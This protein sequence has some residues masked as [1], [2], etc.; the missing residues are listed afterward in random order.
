M[1]ALATPSSPGTSAPS[2]WQRLCLLGILLASAPLDAADLDA[3][4][5][6]FIDGAYEEVIATSMTGRREE[7]GNAEWPIL[8]GEALGQ[9]GRYTE[10]ADALQEACRDFPLELRLRFAAWQATREAGRG[11]EAGEHLNE[12]ERLATVRLWA[13]RTPADRITLGRLALIFGADPKKVLEQFY[14]PIRKAQPELRESYLATGELALEK[15]DFALAAKNFGVAV[16]KFPDDPDAWFGLA[17]AYDPSDSEAMLH[18]LGKVLDL[19][20]N[21]VGAWLL[22]A[23][24]RIDTEEYAEADIALAAA[25]KINANHPEAHACRAVLAHLRSDS[26]LEASERVAALK[27]W[28]DNPAVPHLIGRKLS[29]KYRFAEGAA[30]QRE[31]LKFDGKFLPAKA[32]LANDLLRLGRDDEGWKL[33]GEVQQADPYD[34]VAYNL[35]TLRDVIAKFRTL[36]SE[37]FTVR[38]DPREAD[39]YG[40]DA[41]ALLERAHAALTKKYGLPLRDRTI[42]EIFPD[43]KDFA[44]RTFGL[45]GGAGYLGVCFGRVITAN[46]PASRAG[47]PSSWEAILWHE[48]CHVVTLTMTK[49]KMPRWLSEGISVFEERQARGSW[50]EQMKPRYRA[51]ILGED[52]TPVSQLSS[53]FLKPKTPAH[54][55]FAYY[56]SSLVVEWLAGRWGMEK[57]KQLLA[58]LGRGAEINAALATHFAPI[59]Q[60]DRDFAKHVQELA[61]NTGPKLDWTPPKPADLANAKS[62]ADFLMKNPDNFAALT[63]L[64]QELLDSRQ[65]EAAKKPLLR[66][67]EDYPDEHAADGAYAMLARVHRELGE[68][69]AELAVLTRLGELS[70]DA[71]D[72][73]ERLMQIHAQRREWVKVLEYSARYR[74][75]DPLRPEPWRYEAEASEAAGRNAN[76]IAACR[77]LIELGPSDP[78]GIHYRLAKLL[79]A[80]GDP[81]AKREVLLALEEAPRFR[82]AHE[83]LLEIAGET[84]AP[85]GV[86]RDKRR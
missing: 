70:A 1:R 23:N 38:M 81:G 65:W 22:L 3:A 28:R 30:L 35:T 25:L 37:H 43:Q 80:A 60:L 51:M 6:R 72:A 85:G 54:L 34:V 73:F 49:N 62:A 2:R 21:H 17:R 47:S 33:A 15:N 46:S 74:A 11:R 83:L 69:D 19:N 58:D 82:A 7:P 78:A 5:K 57:V 16:K 67:I 50:G 42:V 41:L 9:A 4:R 63:R 68:G 29:R 71:T 79:H 20:A 59:E 27:L 12:M 45:P 31:A 14:D 18:A 24:H 75:V 40:E 86:G 53:A 52:L 32:Q 44:I 26:K 64:A 8:L 10:A 48:F 55:G 39:I 77:A 76:A 13:Y 56:E 66:L 61:K 84:S 36:T